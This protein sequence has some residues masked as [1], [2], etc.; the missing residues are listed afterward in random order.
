METTDT[1]RSNKQN[2]NEEISQCYKYKEVTGFI[3][4]TSVLDN[5]QSYHNHNMHTKVLNKLILPSPMF[6]LLN[7]IEAL[8]ATTAFQL[9]DVALQTF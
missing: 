8:Q 3:D 7:F 5:K 2:I 1:Y 4:I 6:K 9:N